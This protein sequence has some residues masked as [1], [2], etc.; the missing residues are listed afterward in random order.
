[1][2]L[3]DVKNSILETIK[4]IKKYLY[5]NKCRF[6]L[7]ED[8]NGVCIFIYLRDKIQVDYHIWFNNF[9]NN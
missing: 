1:M 6:Y 5:D 9:D 7:F 3:E 4:L 2:T 8:K